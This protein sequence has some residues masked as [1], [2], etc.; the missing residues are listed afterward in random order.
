MVGGFDW[1]EGKGGGRRG[2]R[3]LTEVR[4]EGEDIT[5]REE[6]ETSSA[7]ACLSNGRKEKCMHMLSRWNA[8]RLRTSKEWYIY[9]VLP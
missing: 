1:W 9:A 4:K 3:R 8:L 2:G 5:F 7:S 6:D